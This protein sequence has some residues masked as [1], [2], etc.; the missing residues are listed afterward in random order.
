MLVLLYPFPLGITVSHYRLFIYLGHLL[1]NF[2][3]TSQL[4]ILFVYMPVMDFP[5][6]YQS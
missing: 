6:L 2:A 3:Y 1:N 4:L 5:C